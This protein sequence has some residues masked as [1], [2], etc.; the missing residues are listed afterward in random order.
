M[1]FLFVFLFDILNVLFYPFEPIFIQI[2]S[3]FSLIQI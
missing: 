3:P 1:I 2:Y